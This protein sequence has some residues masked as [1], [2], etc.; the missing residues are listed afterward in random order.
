MELSLLAAPILGGVIG[1]ITNDIAIRMLFRP[2]KA[3]YLFG[4]RIPFTPGIIPRE[5]GRI[6]EALGGVISNNLMNQDVLSR[7]FLSDEMVAKVRESVCDFID[8]QRR[9]EETVEAF[10]AHYLKP[11]DIAAI[12]KSVNESVTEQISSKLTDSAMG[13]AVA[14][15]AV[16]HV[17][18]K[19]NTGG[20]GDILAQLGKGMGL[21]GALGLGAA[22]GKIFDLIGEPIERFLA[23][24]I[25]EMLRDRGPEIVSGMVD[26]EVESFLKM[27]MC[28]MLQG[29]EEQLAQV[30]DGVE[31]LYRAVMTDH[32]PK[33]LA[34]IDISRIV[35]DRINEMDI[36]E[37]ERLIR[38]VLN[39]ELKAIVWFGALLGT[40]MGAL[41]LLV[42]WLE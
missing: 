18:A 9:N 40:V 38:M 16:E 15:L 19:F 17:K 35:R 22:L 8:E 30:V 39:R 4:K 41:N 11:D 21:F 25:N 34:S 10:L 3:K 26:N 6:A 5:K 24:N 1:Y 32:L 33:I 12:S 14:H 37:T 28:D 31:S 29:R 23:N 2:H 20:S 42:P 13:N 27:P 36:A 7:Y